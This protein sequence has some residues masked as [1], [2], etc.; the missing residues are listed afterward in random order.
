[1]EALTAEW[2]ATIGGQ[3]AAVAKNAC[4]FQAQ[5]GE[6]AGLLRGACTRHVGVFAA[7]RLPR[8]GNG[9]CRRTDHSVEDRQAGPAVP[10]SMSF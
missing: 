8:H 1:L 9:A 7:A 3:F 10:Q 2:D 6:V 5:P 4:D